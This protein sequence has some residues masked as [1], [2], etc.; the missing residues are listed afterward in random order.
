MYTYAVYYIVYIYIYNRERER[1]Y[2]YTYIYIYIYMEV[3]AGGPRSSPRYLGF[4]AHISMIF[5]KG[6]R[7]DLLWRP[8]ITEV[9]VCLLSGLAPSA[10]LS[11]LFPKEHPS[12]P[13]LRHVSTSSHPKAQRFIPSFKLSLNKGKCTNNH[14]LHS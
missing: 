8:K 6:K 14:R 12:P 10:W 11:L 7:L 5:H 2:I 4:G 9:H 13:T 1:D 3:G